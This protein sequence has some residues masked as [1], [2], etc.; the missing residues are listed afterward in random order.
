[1][2]EAETFFYEIGREFP[3]LRKSNMFGSPCLKAR[4]GKSAAMLW[5]DT[6]VVKLKANESGEILKLPGTMQFEPMQGRKMKEWIAVPFAYKSRWKE[7][8][9]S[10]Y[11]HLMEAEG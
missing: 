1:M 8:I 11:E 10:S 4:T 3:L 9:T 7:L 6:L 2:S 5:K